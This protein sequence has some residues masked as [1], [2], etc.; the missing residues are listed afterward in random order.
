MSKSEM[1]TKVKRVPFYSGTKLFTKLLTKECS[2]EC[3]EVSL[4]PHHQKR[5]CIGGVVVIHH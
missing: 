4:I 1:I 2:L 5:H 3:K